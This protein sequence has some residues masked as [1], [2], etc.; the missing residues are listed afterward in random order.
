MASDQ[1]GDRRRGSG[2][3][4]FQARPFR[5]QLPND[6]D[7]DRQELPHLARA[8]A[9]KQTN[10]TGIARRV[11]ALRGEILNHRMPDED[12][13]QTGLLVEFGLEGED[14]EH[15]VKPARHLRDAAAVPGPDLGAD[16][17]DNFPA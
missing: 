6:L 16:V 1:V 2:D 7:Q 8:T 13:A 14:A 12:R 11:R 17:I 4:E 10:E 5:L 15:Q 3:L 9:G